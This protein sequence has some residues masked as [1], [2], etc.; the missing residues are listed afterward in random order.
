METKAEVQYRGMLQPDTVKQIYGFTDRCIIHWQGLRVR[1][2]KNCPWYHR[3]SKQK[4]MN[5]YEPKKYP[6]ESAAINSV[7]NDKY[8]SR[9]LYA[10]KIKFSFM[11]NIKFNPGNLYVRVPLSTNL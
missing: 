10:Y 9:F 5:L 7:Y 3:T 11:I 2:Y 4:K 8:I 6:A 1:D